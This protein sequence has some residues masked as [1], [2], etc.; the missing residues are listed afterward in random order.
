MKTR[1]KQIRQAGPLI[2]AVI[3]I[4]IGGGGGYW[5]RAQR[6]G[7][8]S[9]AEAASIPSLDYLIGPE[10]FSKI[11]NARSCLQGLCTRLRLQVESRRFFAEHLPGRPAGSKQSA[12]LHA[13]GA[14]RDLE[15]GVQEFEGTGEES[16]CAQDLFS[17]L[18]R[19]GRFDR[20]VEVYLKALYEHP[21]HPFVARFAEDAMAVARCAGREEE[22]LAGLRHLSAIPLN[23]E[24]KNAVEAIVAERERGTELT[25]VVATRWTAIQ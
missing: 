5:L 17:E 18:K 6:T 19:A 21:T 22:V 12:E 3:L 2:G 11:K 4:L 9:L 7:E 1:V 8:V 15:L 25:R 10:S 14:I 24:G 16:S 23:F 20:C 13:D